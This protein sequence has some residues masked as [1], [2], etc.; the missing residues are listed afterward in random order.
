MQIKYENKMNQQEEDS[1]DR[2][3]SCDQRSRGQAWRRLSF[4]YSAMRRPYMFQFYT[5]VAIA[6]SNV[7]DVYR[8]QFERGFKTKKRA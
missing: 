8:D 5:R 1:K 4:R 7:T 2:A 6:R 3:P